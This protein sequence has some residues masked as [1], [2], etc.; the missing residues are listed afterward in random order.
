M[1]D[2]RA[3]TFFGAMQSQ[4]ALA[5]RLTGIDGEQTAIRRFFRFS[6]RHC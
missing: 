6:M 5:A 4:D 3:F 2:E 1:A